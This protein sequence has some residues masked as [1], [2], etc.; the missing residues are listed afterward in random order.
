MEPLAAQRCYA[1]DGPIIPPGSAR[2][3]SIG[4]RKAI[5]MRMIG[6]LLFPFCGT[7][8]NSV[9]GT[10]RHFDSLRFTGYR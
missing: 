10:A 1:S 6:A 4:Q 9:T 5:A 3:Y 2:R 8:G 7:P